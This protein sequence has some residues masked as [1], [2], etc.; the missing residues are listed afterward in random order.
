LLRLLLLR[1][2]QHLR[3]QLFAGKLS[4][5]STTRATELLPREQLCPAT[6]AILSH[7]SPPPVCARSLLKIPQLFDSICADA[8][9]TTRNF[10][11]KLKARQFSLP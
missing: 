11:R 1:W 10:P 8:F 5:R 4:G 7:K 6:P 9:S 2:W 3:R